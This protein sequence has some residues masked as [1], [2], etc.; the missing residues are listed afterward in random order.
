MHHPMILQ[1]L[2]QLPEDELREMLPEARSR[3]DRARIEVEQIEEALA[4][5]APPRGRTGQTRERILE[6]VRER[7]PVA[8]KQVIEFMNSD[9]DAAA[10]VVYNALSRMARDGELIR[11]D[12]GYAVPPATKAGESPPAVIPSPAMAAEVPPAVVQAPPPVAA[13]APVPQP[14]T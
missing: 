11:G 7:G 2:A 12:D 5:Q 13:A 10:A 4:V 9:D 3:A 6:F 1:A 14:Q 8:P